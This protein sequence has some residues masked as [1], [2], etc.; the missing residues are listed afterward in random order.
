[1][2]CMFDVKLCMKFISKYLT[3]SSFTSFADIFR[4]VNDGEG[5]NL[6]HKIF[7][8]PAGCKMCN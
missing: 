3:E 4:I 2:K 8:T 5:K 7:Y 1:M 6:Q